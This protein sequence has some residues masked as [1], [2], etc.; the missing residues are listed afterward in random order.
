MISSMNPIDRPFQG[1]AAA[2]FGV[3]NERSIAWSVAAALHDAGARLA[4]SYASNRLETGVRELA[5]SLGDDVLVLPC[6]VADDCQIHAFFNAVEERRGGLDALVHSVAFAPRE[7][8]GLPLYE[9]SRRGYQ[10]T[11][12]VSAFSLAALTRRARPLMEGRGGSMVALTYVGGERVVPNY[13]LMGVAKAAL[14]ASIRYLA[15]ELGPLGIRVNGISAGPVNTL[16]AR[17]IRGFKTILSHY[18]REAPLR[19]NV[20]QREIAQAALFLLGP[21]A[22]GVTGEILHV[23]AGYHV[24]A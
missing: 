1:K 15:H 4:L 3:A 7:E 2:V 12:D 9:V 21:A 8:L 14:E 5:K 17:G 6:D 18:E 16:A 20:T 23:D 19:R 10:R 24:M 13:D 11:Q 22:S